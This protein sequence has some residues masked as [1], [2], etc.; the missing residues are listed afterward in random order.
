MVQ[1]FCQQLDPNPYK[2]RCNP[3][4]EIK[5]ISTKQ[6]KENDETENMLEN[7]MYQTLIRKETAMKEAVLSLDE[8]FDNV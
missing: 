6:T 5:H 7:C 1:L 3:S 4:F 2:V 8:W